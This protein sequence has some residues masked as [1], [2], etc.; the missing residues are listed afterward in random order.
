LDVQGLPEVIYTS[1]GHTYL[2]LPGVIVAE[3][4]EGEVRYLLGDGLGSVRQ[5]VDDTGTVVTYNEFD[6]YGN[7]V[8]NGGEPYGFT[9]EWWED[10]VSLLYLRARWYAPYRKRRVSPFCPTFL[11]ELSS[12]ISLLWLFEKDNG[13]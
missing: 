2:H 7:P 10:D 3:S 11:Y 12:S 9:G 8:Q 4:A 1:E 5:A 6:P 13:K